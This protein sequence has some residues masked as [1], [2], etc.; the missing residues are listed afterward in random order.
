MILT[1]LTGFVPFRA[2]L[3]CYV[4]L[5]R[6]FG[7][8]VCRNTPGTGFPY[9]RWA[10]AHQPVGGC[11]TPYCFQSGSHRTDPPQLFGEKCLTRYLANRFPLFCRGAHTRT[12]KVPSL[13]W[14]SLRD[15]NSRRVS[16]DLGLAIRPLTDSGKAAYCSA[17]GVIAAVA[18]CEGSRRDTVAS[19]PPLGH[20]TA[21]STAMFLFAGDRRCLPA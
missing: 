20:T 4:A 10:D 18:L 9:Q 14:R 16:P 8:T 7:M 11:K 6:R 5:H 19:V 21:L 1:S 2:P 17:C 13:L 15:L 12:N 3:C